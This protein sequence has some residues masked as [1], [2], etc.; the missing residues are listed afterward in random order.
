MSEPDVIQESSPEPESVNEEV[1][2]T[3]EVQQDLNV[4]IDLPLPAEGNIAVDEV[5]NRGVSYKNVAHEYKRKLDDVTTQLSQMNTVL[6]SIQSGQAQ[7]TQPTYTIAE[8]E[9][10]KQQNP[11]HA[12]WCEQEKAR[13]QKEDIVASV[14]DEFEARNAKQQEAQVRQ[15]SLHA[16]AKAYPQIFSKDESG[17]VIGYDNSNPLTQRIAAYAKDP[18]IANRPDGILYA[19]KLA[20]ADL[21][22]AGL[23]QAQTKAQTQQAV[24]GDLQRKTAIEGG[25][26]SAIT[27]AS[28]RQVALD[29]LRDS[30]ERKDAR[31]ALKQIMLNSGRLKE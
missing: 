15:Q 12:A 2:A 3:P 9:V 19:A 10:Y 26:L 16:V 23:V 29:G 7:E 5:D 20:Y 31:S 25:G 6:E 30:G 21:A 13:I 18:T 11:E 4:P 8:L 17:N 14:R 1:V 24:I 28:P 27:P 22:A